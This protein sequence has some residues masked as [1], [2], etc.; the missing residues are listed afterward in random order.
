MKKITFEKL[1][2]MM[3]FVEDGSL[4]KSEFWKWLSENLEI[5]NYLNLIEKYS[6]IKL[7]AIDF[8]YKYMNKVISGEDD[9]GVEYF[10]MQYDMYSFFELFFPY[11]GIEVENCFKNTENYD[12]IFNSGLYEYVMSRCKDDYYSLKEKCDMVIGIKD[13]SVISKLGE[14]VEKNINISEFNKSMVKFD[15]IMKKKNV[16]ENL[17]F[18]NS[19]NMFNDPNLL[20]VIDLVK[21]DWLDN[22]KKL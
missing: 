16:R 9:I 6:I 22:K 5:K 12:L 20:K 21:E 7:F 18:I 13:L 2:D 3:M 8:Q 15:S 17:K 11:I 1:R 10:Y 19:I 14:F 4:S